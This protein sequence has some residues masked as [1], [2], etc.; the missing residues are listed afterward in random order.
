MIKCKSIHQP[1]SADDGERIFVDR[2]WPEG[3]ST[4]AAAILH[5]LQDVAPS[6]ELWRYKFAPHNWNEYRR[7][8]WQELSQK[9]LR[10][11]L[12]ELFKKSQ[13]G[14]VTLVYGTDNETHNNAAAL[15]EYLEK[16]NGPAHG[17]RK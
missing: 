13:Q 9:S 3:V 1:A 2:L 14:T 11:I 7:L 17:Q 10:P 12:E 6:Y 8:Y 15:K 16:F 4:Y 5:W